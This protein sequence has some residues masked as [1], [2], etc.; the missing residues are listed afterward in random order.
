M[1]SYQHQCGQ[2][3]RRTYR[4]GAGADLVNLQRQRGASE[5][6]IHIVI[7]KNHRIGESE[8][9]V[10]LIEL[11]IHIQELVESDVLS[12]RCHRIRK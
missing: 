11:R 1:H 6:M 9:L 12:I 7:G 2:K 8:V 3:H 4:R 5:A 10:L